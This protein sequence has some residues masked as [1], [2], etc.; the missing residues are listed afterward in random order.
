M[1]LSAKNHE[2]LCSCVLFYRTQWYSLAGF[3]IAY[4]RRLS[5]GVF[6]KQWGGVR[7]DRHGTL[8]R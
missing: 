3:L 2:H 8:V 5:A 6:R 1:F 7:L 4:E